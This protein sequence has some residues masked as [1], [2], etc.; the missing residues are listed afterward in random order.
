MGVETALIAGIALSAGA[1]VAG[2]FA[3]DKASKKEANALND[4]A[5]IAQDEATAEANR[6]ATEVRQF[7]RRQKLAFLKNGVTLEGSPLLILDETLASGQEEVDAIMKR[8]TAQAKLLRE[9]A[10]QARNK[11]RAALIGGIGS[12]ASTVIGG[13]GIGRSA[14][15]FGSTPATTSDWGTNFSR[16][17]MASRS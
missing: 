17:T 2:G 16:A 3:A 4:Q 7:Q 6:R 1:S 13:Y 11:G 9:N 5:G 12:A 8:G 15:M 14:G 10:A